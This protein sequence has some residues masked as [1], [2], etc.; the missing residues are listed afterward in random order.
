MSKILNK[1][2]IFALKVDIVHLELNTL[3]NFHALQAHSVQKKVWMINHNVNY[4][5]LDI[6]VSLKDSKLL[7]LYW[8]LDIMVMDNLVGPFLILI[9]VHRP[10][11]AKKARQIQSHL[12]QMVNGHPVLELNL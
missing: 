2:E 10:P 7:Q 9:Y 12:A 1:M 4:V 6:T 3:M 11:I 8:W 5:H